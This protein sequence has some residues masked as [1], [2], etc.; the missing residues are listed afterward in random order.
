M[1]RNRAL[2]QS[3]NDFHAPAKWSG[4]FHPD[5]KKITSEEITGRKVC[6]RESPVMSS[7]SPVR[8][9]HMTVENGGYHS[10]DEN[11]KVTWPG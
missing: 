5:E 1:L 10:P 7:A 9:H 8:F 4:G 11:V 2:F 3:R 6:Q